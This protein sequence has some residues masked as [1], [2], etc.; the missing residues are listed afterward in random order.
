[1]I[2]NVKFSSYLQNDIKFLVVFDHSVCMLIA[3][4][5]GEQSQKKNASGKWIFFEIFFSCLVY[6]GVVH[7]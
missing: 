6:C 1:M 4:Y 7:F 3:A 5:V 2:D